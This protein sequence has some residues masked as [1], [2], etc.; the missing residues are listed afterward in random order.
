MSSF[1]VRLTRTP[2]CFLVGLLSFISFEEED[3]GSL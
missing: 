1:A 2:A 3:L